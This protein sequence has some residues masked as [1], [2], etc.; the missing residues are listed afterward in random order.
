MSEI[1]RNKIIGEQI[2]RKYIR[3]KLLA[4]RNV[5]LQQES[6]FRNFVRSVLAE[7]EIADDPNRSTGIN[8]LA[9]L[10]K[11]IVPVLEDAYKMLT[12]SDEQRNSFRNHI[13][14][15]IKNTIAPIDATEKSA[16]ESI[17]YDVDFEILSEK[18]KVS[19]DTEDGETVDA[20]GEFIDI[21]P[22]E[23]DVLDDFGI[24]GQDETGRNFAQK[25]FDRIEAQVVDHYEMLADDND[26]TL[27][28]DY[29]LTNIMLYF[30]KFET[31][32]VVSPEE[33]TTPEYEAEKAEQE[34]EETEE[35]PEEPAEE[36]I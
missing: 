11:R 36:E 15:A 34:S 19:V 8:V 2:L 30:D 13:V 12:T 33:E 26:K 18:V 9:D 7:E 17:V 6:K 25:T 3:T 22:A 31:A 35:I 4:K 5:E 27:F 23:D 20:E 28:R 14:A 1:N 16:N 24:K 32:L 10:L 29:L 21:A